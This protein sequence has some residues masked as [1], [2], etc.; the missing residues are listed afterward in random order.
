MVGLP[1]DTDETI[2][3]SFTKAA[4]LGIDEFAVYPLIPYPGTAIAKFPERFGYTIENKDF[5]DYVQIGKDGRT[6]FAL[7]HKNFNPEDVKRWLGI[8]TQI[9]K[10]G[11]VDH[12]SESEVAK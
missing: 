8:A 12:M 10:S 1:F 9:L 4:E 7:K 2:E 11:G 6:C 3:Q 5:L